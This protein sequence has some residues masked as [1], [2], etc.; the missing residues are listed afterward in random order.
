MNS[1]QNTAARHLTRYQYAAETAHAAQAMLLGNLVAGGIDRARGLLQH[2][3][4]P[5]VKAL[6]VPR[7]ALLGS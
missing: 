5:F 2:V 7:R 1:I 3:L 6:R 4:R